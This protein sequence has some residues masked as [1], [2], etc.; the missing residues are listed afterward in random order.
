MPLTWCFPLSLAGTKLHW[1]PLGKPEGDLFFLGGGIDVGR[2]S[3][4]PFCYLARGCDFFV[5]GVLYSFF[6]SVG[7]RPVFSPG[8]APLIGRGFFL[9]GAWVWIHIRRWLSPGPRSYSPFPRLGR[10]SA[11]F[12]RYEHPFVQS[13]NCPFPQRPSFFF[14]SRWVAG[15]FGSGGF[16]IFPGSFDALASFFS[17]ASVPAGPPPQFS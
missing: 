9:G 10:Q 12:P 17:L 15:P 8:A 6:I 3:W 4:I 11:R 16:T 13:D 7:A 14:P 2:L 5:F 1:S